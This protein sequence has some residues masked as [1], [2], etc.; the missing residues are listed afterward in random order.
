MLNKLI[1]ER[2]DTADS[3]GLG[4]VEG[5]FSMAVNIWLMHITDKDSRGRGH[6][7]HPH[8]HDRCH[9]QG[10]DGPARTG[11]DGTAFE[12]HRSNRA[13]D[14]NRTRMTSLEG[15][16]SAIELRPPDRATAGPPSVGYRSGRPD[17]PGQAGFRSGPVPAPLSSGDNKATRRSHPW[18]R[19]SNLSKSA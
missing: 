19:W 17:A 8:G 13:G 4:N 11:S 9:S 14:G 10:A 18:H 6:R 2:L 16:G 12:L 1:D 15:W 5:A 3:Q 7:R